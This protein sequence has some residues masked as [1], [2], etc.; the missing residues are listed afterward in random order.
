[1]MPSSVQLDHAS[2]DLDG[3]RSAS[4]CSV[5]QLTAVVQ[6]PCPHRAIRFQRN[7]MTLL[8]A[9]IILPAA[10]RDRHH[11]GK[12]NNLNWRM[13]LRSRPITKLTA[14]V[15]SPRPYGSIGLQS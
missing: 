7:G 3:D 2:F 13:P 10:G 15:K 8:V 1:M 14:T 9:R 4:G 6:S 11:V 5:S 12:T